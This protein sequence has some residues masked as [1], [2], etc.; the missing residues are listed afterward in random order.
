MFYSLRAYVFTAVAARGGANYNLIR[1]A[2]ASANHNLRA[3][4]FYLLM[5]YKH[6][7][8][9]SPRPS[10]RYSFVCPYDSTAGVFGEPLGL[11]KGGTRI[12]G[13]SKG[14]D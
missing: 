7:I 13:A 8:A 6:L 10:V 5:A 4:M 1:E 11:L 2:L 12:Y 9:L 3:R 14:L